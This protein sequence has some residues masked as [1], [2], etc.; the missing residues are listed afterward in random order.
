VR[1]DLSVIIL[2]LWVCR[3][4]VVRHRKPKSC[5]PVCEVNRTEHCIILH[6]CR[7]LI[8]LTDGDLSVD[9]LRSVTTFHSYVTLCVFVWRNRAKSEG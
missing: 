1:K 9:I 6:I 4:V 3:F 2:Y 7:V 5:L 8:L